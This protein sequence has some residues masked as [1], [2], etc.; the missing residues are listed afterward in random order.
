VLSTF[1]DIPGLL[2]RCR[3]PRGGPRGGAIAGLCQSNALSMLHGDTRAEFLEHWPL[4]R[5]QGSRNT[6][7]WVVTLDRQ[8]HLRSVR[9]TSQTPPQL[10]G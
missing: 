5:P 1:S 6:S 8:G 2:A 10:L 4:S 9:R 3:I 7:G